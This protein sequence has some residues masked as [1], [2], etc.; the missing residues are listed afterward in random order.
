MNT[1][2]DIQGLR[3]RSFGS[4]ALGLVG[5]VFFWWVPLGMVLSLSGL[6]FG[7]IDCVSARR[8][9]LDYRLSI[10]GLLVC[11][12]ALA[13]DIVIAVLGLQSITFGS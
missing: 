8:R 10:A 12:A 6:M 13:L 2:N 1:K 3:A 4:I 5:G 11:A 9:S 7:F